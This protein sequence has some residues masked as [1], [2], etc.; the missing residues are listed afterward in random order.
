MATVGNH[1]S[2][3]A[4][5]YR[6]H[7]FKSYYTTDHVEFNCHVELVV[8]IGYIYSVSVMNRLSRA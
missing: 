7:L 8:F 6:S 5:F 3:T 1:L 2:Y 4:Y